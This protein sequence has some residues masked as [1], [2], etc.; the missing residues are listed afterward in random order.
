VEI[1][2]SKLLAAELQTDEDASH[3][4]LWLQCQPYKKI[5]SRILAAIEKE[6]TNET[7]K[8]R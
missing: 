4:L 5:R 1:E 6:R 8:D 7:R 3:I 2:I